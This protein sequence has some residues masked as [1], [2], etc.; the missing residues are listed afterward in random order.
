M[1]KI[2]KVSLFALSAVLLVGCA[3][4]GKTEKEP[5]GKD[6]D[7]GTT[8]TIPTVSTYDNKAYNDYLLN[9]EGKQ[10]S[11]SNQWEGYGIGDPFIMRWNGMYYLY[12]SSLDSEI[13]VRGYKS[14]DLVNWAPMTGEGLKEGYVSQDNVSLAA[15]A[16][17]VYYFN[18]TFYMYTS[19]AGAG[20]YVLT[21][22]APEGP[23]VKATDNFGMSIDGSVLIDDDEQ[24]YFMIAENGGIRMARMTDMLTVESSRP[25]LTDT[26]IGGWTE[27]A[28]LLKRDGI[29]YLTYTGNHVASDGY[30][31]AYSTATDLTGNYSGAFTRAQNNPVALNTES[32]LKGIGHSS[33]VM[34]PD[35]DSH[36]LVYHYLNSSGGP[37]R[38]LGIDRL[39]F[40]GTMMSVSPQLEKSVKPA[41]PAFY[42]T[43]KD[44]EKFAAEGSFL[45]SKTAAPANFTAEFNVTNAGETAYVFGYTDAQNYSSVTVDLTAKTVK[46]NKVANGTASEIASGTLVHDF[47]ADKL[48][49]VRVA[50]RDGK[51]DV[52]FDNM[53][54]IDNAEYT[55]PAGKI[56]YSALAEAA[57]VGYTAYSDV[58]MGMSDEREAKQI[59]GF[60]GAKNYLRG[61]DYTQAPVLGKGSGLAT[62][63]EESEEE[64]HRFTGWSKLT[65]ANKGDSVSYLVYNG[66]AGRY[67]LELVYPATDGGKKIGV[68]LDG[69]NG[70]TVYRCTLPEVET[71]NGYVKALIGEFDLGVGA[72]VVRLE[73]VGDKVNYTAFRFVETSA[74]TPEFTDS[75]DDYV[76][77]GADYKTIWK[78]KEGGHYAKAGTRQLVY[79]GDNRIT[80]FTLEI[81]VQ[82]EG[83]TGSS[84]AGIVFRAKNYASS[85]HDGY[86]SIQGYYFAMSN[87]S[88]KLARLDYA[89]DTND[90]ALDAGLRPQ[91]DTLYKIKIQ[92]RGNRITVWVGGEKIFDVTD[93]WGFANG[94]VGLYTD[95]AAAVFKNLKIYA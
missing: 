34:G 89:D 20:H 44:E 87:N 2:G 16:P 5:S 30:R 51:V 12:C 8:Y 31:I 27:G 90:I 85:P 36:Y 59:T 65:L 60:V 24:M 91:S 92:A 62:I 53:T 10:S 43:G 72:H 26:N 42:A 47:A 88:V 39:T 52:V 79:F 37:N 13:G 6:P 67:G 14:A 73:N 82:L 46:L 25:L 70:G 7:D 86:E 23:F 33:T 84:T 61:D 77:K 19:P 56:G 50:S 4:C 9:M 76:E 69:V 80:D 11:I 78:I 38:S 32:E 94:K 21:S 63:N 45:L 54:K 41:L 18:G 48:H 22:S 57:T 71:E 68:K 83:S 64:D 81:E 3:A 29:Y 95:G 58:A 49:T 66:E 35:M 55:V 1:K 75:L 40:D 15:Y 74:V 17:E 93:D 28:Y